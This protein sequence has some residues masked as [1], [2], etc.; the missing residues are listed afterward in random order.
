MDVTYHMVPRKYF[1]SLSESEDY[2]PAQFAQD[3][4]IHCTDGEYIAIVKV[5]QM[6]RDRKGDWIFPISEMMG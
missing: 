3:G 1:E 2:F 5:S 4:F 6:V